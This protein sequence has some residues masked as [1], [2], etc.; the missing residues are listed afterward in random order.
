[1]ITQ[2]PET[3]ISRQL[4]EQAQRE[5]WGALGE[6]GTSSPEMHD[7]ERKM[8]RAVR[9]A[10]RATGLPIF[11]HVP[12]ESCPSCALEQLEIYESAGVNLA[13]LC[14][15]HQSTVKRTDDPA[16]ETHKE[17][18]RHGAYIGFDT[19][20]HRMSSSFTLEGEKVD[21]LL[22]ALEAGF[23]D[24]ILL[25]FDF[26]NTTQIKANWGNGFSA[27]L[28]QFVPKLRYFW[29]PEQTIKKILVD[30]PRTW[31]AYEPV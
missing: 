24:Q 1:M 28:L 19:V 10:Y 23:E 27:V 9:L 14:I 7:D 20:G 6:V 8:L 13:N 26:A 31:L 15:G 25:S 21:M 11:T 3:E 29:V 30:N 18:A 5:R 12:H 17:I 22:N 16:W 4:V 2:L